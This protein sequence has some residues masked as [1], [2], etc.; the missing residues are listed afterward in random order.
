MP[1]ATT[2]G[3]F[4]YK[5]INNELKKQINTVA[6]TTPLKGIPVLLRMDGFTTMI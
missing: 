3:L 6:V 1:G 4:A 2:T 5:P